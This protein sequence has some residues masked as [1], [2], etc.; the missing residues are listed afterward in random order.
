MSDEVSM[1]S[2]HHQFS[3]EAHKATDVLYSS[4]PSPEEIRSLL[5]LAHVAH[6]H[7]EKQEDKKPQN[8]SVSYW[9][10]SRAYS[11]N[12]MGDRALHYAELALQTIENEGLLPSFYGYCNEALARA[13]RLLGNGEMTEKHLRI[14]YQIA[15]TVPNDHAKSYL[16]DQIDRIKL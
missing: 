8:V 6:W 16:L 15:E 4:N 5:E 2:A 12:N 1:Q 11:A 7:W 14:A 10:L 13:H 9:L 3:V